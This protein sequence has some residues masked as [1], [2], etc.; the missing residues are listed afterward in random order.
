MAVSAVALAGACSA[1]NMTDAQIFERKETGEN[2]LLIKYHYL[3]N[4]KKYIDSASIE[5]I[6]LAGDT[7]QV[8]YAPS[9]PSKAIPQ[10]AR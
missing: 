7:I 2:Q 8:K 9:N 10:L 1:K 3:V 6:A 5:N 4:G